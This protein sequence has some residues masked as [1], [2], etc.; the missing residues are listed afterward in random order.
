MSV[1]YRKAK[2]VKAKVFGKFQSQAEGAAPRTSEVPSIAN[3]AKAKGRADS[4]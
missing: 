3:A 4:C 1:V 2:K